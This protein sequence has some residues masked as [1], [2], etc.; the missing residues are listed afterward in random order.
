MVPHAF[1]DLGATATQI[2]DTYERVDDDAATNVAREHGL[3]PP[4]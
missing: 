4:P 1:T 2:L 3:L